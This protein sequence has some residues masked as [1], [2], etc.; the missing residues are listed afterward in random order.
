M[1]NVTIA[2]AAPPKSS[3]KHDHDRETMIDSSTIVRVS[4]AMERL[5][6]LER[7]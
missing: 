7:S 5:I 4:V 1:G 6:R 2:R 3:R